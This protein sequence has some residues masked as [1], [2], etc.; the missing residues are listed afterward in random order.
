MKI[1]RRLVIGSMLALG[2]LAGARA[3]EVHPS[4]YSFADLYR[5]TVAGGAADARAFPGVA[6][7]PQ[8]RV[9][10]QAAAVEPRFTV[11]SVPDPRG[12]VLLVAG[13]AAAAWVA[14]RRLTYA[15]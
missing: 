3:D 8:V 6:A 7:E 15:Y 11:T 12:W 13:L 5:V 14:H 2:A 9:A 10:A 4:L 1:V